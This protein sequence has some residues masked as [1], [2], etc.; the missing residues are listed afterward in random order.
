MK[1]GIFDKNFLHHTVWK[2]EKKAGGIKKILIFVKI[3]FLA[4]S[5][6]NEQLFFQKI[7]YVENF[8]Q[9]FF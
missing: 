7:F 1:F 9:N 3:G 8:P 6:K 2:N 4:V 5:D